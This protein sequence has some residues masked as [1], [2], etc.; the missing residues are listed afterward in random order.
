MNKNNNISLK[1]LE[2]LII[3]TIIGVGILSLSSDVANMLG[4]DG[5]IIIVISGF[6]AMIM[7][8]IMIKLCKLYPGRV[9]YDFGKDIIGP[10]L[11]NV[12]NIIYLFHFLALS[13]FTLRIFAE[14]I[15]I[16]L[17]GRTPIEIIILSML[18]ATTY[19]ARSNIEIIGRMAVFI[20]PIVLVTTGIF[21]LVTIP[22]IDFTNILPIFRIS[23]AD[24]KRIPNGTGIIFFS[25]IG[26]EILFI[27][28]AYVEGEKGATKHSIKG[29]IYVIVIYLVT[30]FITLSGFGVFELKREIWPSLSIMREVELPGFFVEN[31]D[32]LILAAWILVVF[33]TLGPTLYS[34]SVVLSKI[35]NTKKHSLFVL[36]MTPIILILSL[37]PQ[38]MSEI[39]SM[40]FILLKYLGTFVMIICPVSMY[41][42]ALIKKG[43]KK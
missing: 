12:I 4:N 5:W 40:M 15:K 30:F 43:G 25:Y 1:Q 38:N 17:L 6:L 13:A 3:T 28:M 22:V 41:I 33:A 21:V 31:I 24:L 39:Y 16:F 23:L 18:F 14:I 11:F 27:A 9:Y 37:I 32:G 20:L 7:M 8:Y 36:P 10:K 29:I 34:G 19:I 35:L 42:I 26:F 2:A